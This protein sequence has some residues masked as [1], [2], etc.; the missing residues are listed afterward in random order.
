MTRDV[1]IINPDQNLIDAARMMANGD[2]GVL[3]VAEGDRLIGMITDRDIVVRALAQGK[4]GRTMSAQRALSALN[5]CRKNTALL[6]SFMLHMS[7][8]AGTDIWCCR[9]DGGTIF[10]RLFLY[11]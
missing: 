8:L 6:G 3:P 4:E 2:C 1:G 7:D 9:I 10:G 11:G 5:E